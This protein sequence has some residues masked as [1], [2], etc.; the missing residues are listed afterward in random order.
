MTVA[1]GEE[2]GLR[3][4]M[5]AMSQTCGEKR[6]AHPHVHALVTRGGWSG[7]GKWVP[8]PYVSSSAAERLFRHKVIS[9]LQR[10]EDAWSNTTAP[11]RTAAD[12]KSSCFQREMSLNTSRCRRPK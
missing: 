9:L 6:N 12:T 11:T 1:A 7:S 2:K 5:V 8:V 4:G 3:P 10:G